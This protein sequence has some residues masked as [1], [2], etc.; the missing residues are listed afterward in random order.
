MDSVLLG[1]HR[2][3]HEPAL[4]VALT[5]HLVNKSAHLPVSEED[6]RRILAAGVAIVQSAPTDPLAEAG[7]LIVREWGR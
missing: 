3:E 2:S 6:C 7:A 4:K 5:R 1:V